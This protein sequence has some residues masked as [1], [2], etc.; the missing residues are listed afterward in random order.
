MIV[1]QPGPY[2]YS[3]NAATAVQEDH[4]EEYDPAIMRMTQDHGNCV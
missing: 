1:N 3:Q 4:L 2:L